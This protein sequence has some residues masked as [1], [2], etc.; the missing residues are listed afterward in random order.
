ML[1]GGQR[2]GNDSGSLTAGKTSNSQSLWQGNIFLPCSL[3]DTHGQL[4]TDSEDGLRRLLGQYFLAAD[5]VAA[6]Y[7]VLR[8]QHTALA[9]GQPQRGCR[10][11]VTGGDGGLFGGFSAALQQPNGA[12]AHSMEM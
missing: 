5:A 9:V 1:H 2:R 10:L 3:D 8:L 4:I 11:P 12:V 7:A 6:H